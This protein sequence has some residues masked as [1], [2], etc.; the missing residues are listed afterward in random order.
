MISEDTLAPLLNAVPSYQARWQRDRGGIRAETIAHEFFLW[1]AV[2]LA[3]RAAAGD[4]SELTWMFAAVEQLYREGNEELDTQLTV[5]FLE[6]LIHMAEDRG[7]DLARVAEHITGER[8]R[9]GWN[10][11]YAYTH[12]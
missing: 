12:P 10:A 1:L 2:H 3:D 5:G 4:F 6:G 7:V 8:A 9:R 11:A